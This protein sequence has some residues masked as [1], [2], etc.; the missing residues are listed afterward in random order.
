MKKPAS[1][2]TVTTIRQASAVS[3]AAEPVVGA[4]AERGE[5]P[6]RGARTPGV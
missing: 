1:F 2:H 3:L 4:G 6:F 5:S